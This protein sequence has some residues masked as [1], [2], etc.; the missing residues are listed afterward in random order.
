MMSMMWSRISGGRYGFDVAVSVQKIKPPFSALAHRPSVTLD[1]YQP[2]Y[3]Q[4]VAPFGKSA[5]EWVWQGV[6]EAGG[7]GDSVFDGTHRSEEHT[8]EL[9]SPC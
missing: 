8:S 6:L 1:V 2:A 3:D 5:R 9:Q 4:A 7:N